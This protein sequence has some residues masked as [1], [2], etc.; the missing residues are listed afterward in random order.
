MQG[1][2]I[3]QPKMFYSFSL[4]EFVP[5]D[6]FYRKLAATLDLQFLYRATASYYGKEG[7]KSIDP[8][9]F[10]K[11]CI[12]GYLNNLNS[13]R[14]LIRFCADSLSVRWFLGYDIDEELPW[15][16]TISR[17]RQLLGEELFL[18]LFQKV[19][20]LCIEKGM[21]S[22]K[23][24][25]VDSA[26]IKANAS[27]DSLVEKE[28]MED[29]KE[30]ANELNENSEYKVGAARK[31]SVEQHHKW[32]EKAYKGMPG[33]GKKDRKDENGKLIRPKYLS[34]HTHYCPTDPDAKIS[35]KP[36][37][38]RQLNYFGQVGVDAENHVITAATADYADKRDSQC[39]EK[40]SEQ[41]KDNF[42]QNGFT[43][44]ELLADTG[45]SSGKALK[46]LEEQGIDAYIPNF[47]QYKPEREGFIFNQEKNRYECQRG[48]RA[49]LTYKGEKTN[50]K[51]YS[52]HTYR[53]SET[54]CKNCPLQQQ[55]CGKATKFKKI[56]HSIY[57]PYYDRMHEK[58]LRNPK[59]TK[60]MV[61]TRSK[62]VEPVLGT[63]LN[64]LGMKRVYTRGIA[65]AQKHV[66]LSATCYNLKKL[67]KF[68]APK[69]QT[70]VQVSRQLQESAVF[71]KNRL[72]AVILL[73]YKPCHFLR[74]CP[75]LKYKG[76]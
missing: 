3:H 49:I 60:Q 11:I 57:K 55:C 4:D 31:K 46:Y 41:L 67:L 16:S 71:F 38:A 40:L 15:H 42:T 20:H 14:A 37:K 61:K 75:Q 27:M 32:K 1:K 76:A 68:P 44:N 74:N 52:K 26:F 24:Q 63:L 36:G 22:G 62:T 39:I 53:S 23:R 18:T 45:Y 9:V 34:N 65:A 6:S 30:Y 59:Y 66:L 17:N 7:Q 29:G 43:I 8:V 2:K 48:N 28:I 54:D 33:G 5:K 73:T 35:V 51:S 13:D 70:M 50:N 56:E 58:L 10:F 69:V 12:V 64:F 25:A 47:G 72:F 21:V 19:L